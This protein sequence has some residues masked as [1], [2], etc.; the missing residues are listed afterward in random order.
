[1]TLSRWQSAVVFLDHKSGSLQS[2]DWSM[3]LDLHQSCRAEPD[4]KRSAA[5]NK[6]HWLYNSSVCLVSICLSMRM[7]FDK[8]N[9][10]SSFPVAALQMELIVNEFILYLV[11]PVSIS[12]HLPVQE[13]YSLFQIMIIKTFNLPYETSNLTLIELDW[14]NYCNKHALEKSLLSPVIIQMFTIICFDLIVPARIAY[15]CPFLP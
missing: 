12:A 7:P 13:K 15:A 6:E 5:V 1:M 4:N 11:H 8:I 3:R 2:P 9:V 10:E 14:V